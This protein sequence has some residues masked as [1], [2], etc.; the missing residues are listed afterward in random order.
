MNY[1]YRERLKSAKKGDSIRDFES[2][3]PLTNVE[4][5][6]GVHPGGLACSFPKLNNVPTP[7]S[8]KTVTNALFPACSRGCPG[9]QPP[10]KPMISAL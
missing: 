8:K 1:M 7:R 6:L 2:D 10:G 5:I 4:Q 9:G 3:V